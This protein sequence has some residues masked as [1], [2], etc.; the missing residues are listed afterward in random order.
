[1]LSETPPEV[2]TAC[3]QDATR[4]YNQMDAVHILPGGESMEPC[5][6]MPA[7]GQGTE[8][9]KGAWSRPQYTASL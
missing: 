4:T 7:W 2:L 1:M 5:P 9:F 6:R 3:H 8:T